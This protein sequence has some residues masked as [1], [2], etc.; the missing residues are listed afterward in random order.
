[1]PELPDPWTDDY[2]AE[3]AYFASEQYEKDSERLHLAY[4]REA[5]ANP[6][7]RAMLVKVHGETQV[8]EW[9]AEAATTL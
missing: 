1:M 3:D 5:A 9:I 6:Q 8:E 7:F 4:V 2:T